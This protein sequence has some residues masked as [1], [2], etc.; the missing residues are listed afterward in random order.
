VR[1]QVWRAPSGFST[2]AG[3][4]SVVDPSSGEVVDY[5]FTDDSGGEHHATKVADVVAPARRLLSPPEATEIESEFVFTK[6]AF[7]AD[8]AGSVGVG[9]VLG[10]R[11]DFG[12]PGSAQETDSLVDL[13]VVDCTFSAQGG[14][15]H[16][17]TGQR[18]DIT[19]GEVSGPGGPG[20][21]TAKIAWGDGSGTSAG[22]VRQSGGVLVVAG[23]HRYGH[24]GDY[25]VHV[26]VK[27]LYTGTKHPATG[28]VHVRP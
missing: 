11:P 22:V 21:Y 14:D 23:T 12:R 27:Q 17:R 25:P 28:Q 24:R 13:S 4:S 2:F 9:D 16:A 26:T 1:Y 7:S 19:V 8:L 15:Y 18:A 10:L 20:D 3:S 6:A 5:V